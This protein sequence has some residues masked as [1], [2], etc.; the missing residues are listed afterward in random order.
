MGVS[1]CKTIIFSAVETQ[2]RPFYTDVRS[3]ELTSSIQQANYDYLRTLPNPLPK[4]VLLNKEP[5]SR[6]EHGNG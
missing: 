5:K 4:G 1:V 3:P 6:V 2:S